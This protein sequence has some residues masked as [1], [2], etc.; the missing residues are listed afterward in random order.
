MK[1]ARMT[2]SMKTVKLPKLRMAIALT[3]FFAAGVTAQSDPLAPASAQWHL[4]DQY[5]TD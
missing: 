5:C 2:D 1:S 4:L 3:A